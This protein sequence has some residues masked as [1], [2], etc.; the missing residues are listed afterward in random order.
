MNAQ[1]S[2]GSIESGGKA[3]ESGLTSLAR[4]YHRMEATLEWL[5]DNFESQPSLE[6][7]AGQTGLTPHHFQRTFSRWVGLSPKKFV[8]FLSLKHAKQ[9]LHASQSV[10]DAA[11]SAGLSGAE[12]LHDLF[13]SLEAVTPGEYKQRGADLVIRYGYHS[14][15]FGECLLLT[16]DR[17]I[18]GLAFVVNGDRD[19]ALSTLRCGWE[20]A[21]MEEDRQS[22]GALVE[23]IFTAQSEQRTAGSLKVLVRGSRL[24]V[25]VWEA[26]L[27]VPTGALLSYSE[28][29]R[30]V[31]RPDAVR[32]VAGASARNAIA[33]LIPCHRAIRKTGLLGGY[34]WGLPRKLAMLSREA[35]QARL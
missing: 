2:P 29:A 34:R 8:Q 21:S 23:Q 35:V 6:A 26:L 20:N 31:Q 15:P 5:V 9:C 18:C 4:D 7:I 17:G 30:R 12:R 14:S 16:T 10:L 25:K 13:V 3:A 22:T 11:F 32:A 24:Q 33:Y 19:S 28:L 1:A 27:K